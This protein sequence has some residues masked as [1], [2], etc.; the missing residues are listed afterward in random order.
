[1]IEEVLTRRGG[2]VVGGSSFGSYF[3]TERIRV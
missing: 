2:S 1:M 3:I